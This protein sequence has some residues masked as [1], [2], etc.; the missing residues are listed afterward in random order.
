MAFLAQSKACSMGLQLQILQQ[1]TRGRPCLEA[2]SIAA[3]DRKLVQQSVP[4]S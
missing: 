3:F 4:H 2:M 1:L